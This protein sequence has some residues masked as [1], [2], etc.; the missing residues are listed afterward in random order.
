MFNSPDHFIPINS[1]QPDLSNGM[2]YVFDR[3]VMTMTLFYCF[4]VEIRI[5]KYRLSTIQQK[6]VRGGKKGKNG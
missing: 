4:K 3:G 5:F 6:L 1:L 2:Q